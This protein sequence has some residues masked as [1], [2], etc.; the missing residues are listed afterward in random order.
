MNLFRRITVALADAPSDQGLLEYARLIRDSI[1]AEAEFRFVHVLPDAGSVSLSAA[2]VRTHGAALDSIRGRVYEYLG[3]HRGDCLVLNGSRVDRLLEHCAESG[4]DVILLG[5]RQVRTGRRSLVRRLAM[6]A[7]CSLWMVPEGSAARISK[8][9]VGVDF[10]NCSAEALRVAAFLARRM[11]LGNCIAVHVMPREDRI[12]E[13]AFERFLGAIDLDETTVLPRVENA[14]SVASAL[15]MIARSEDA[16]L[17]VMG[18][19]GMSSSAAV[20]LG[21]ESE[22]MLSESGRPVL[23]TRRRGERLGLLEVLLDR[24][25]QTR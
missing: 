12:G 6:K 14:G 21:T 3:D 19:R 5:H 24:D 10:S 25:L 8:V 2:P 13:T 11:Q 16:D 1:S 17:I 15:H 9:L 18:T 7:P 22:Q 4:S 20:L 23:V